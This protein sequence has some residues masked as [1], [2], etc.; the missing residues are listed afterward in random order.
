MAT[1]QAK[2]ISE[3]KSIVDYIRKAIT[4][5]IEQQFDLIRDKML[6]DLNRRKNEIVAGV[7]L[8]VE[9]QID[10]QNGRDTTIITIREITKQNEKA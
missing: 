1:E 8:S 3:N 2:D 7:L 10:I 4:E 5:D 6:A 9:K